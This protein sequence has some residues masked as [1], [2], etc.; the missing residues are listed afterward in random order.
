MKPVE[1]LENEHVCINQ[2]LDLFTRGLKNLE[3]GQKP[4]RKF[5]DRLLHYINT[6]VEQYHAFKEEHV[7]VK[8]TTTGRKHSIAAVLDGEDMVLFQEIVR[9][10]P[11]SETVIAYCIRLA[12]ATRPTDSLATSMVRKYLKWGAGPRSGQFMTLGAKALAL[13]KARITP[14]FD[15]VKAISK[16]V[17]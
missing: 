13:T 3:N 11:V 6:F 9:M 15:D 2:A 17:L 1:I 8:Q 7:M 10:A 16:L 14:S 5:F 12:R 4:S